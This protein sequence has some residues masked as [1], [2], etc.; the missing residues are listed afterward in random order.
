MQHCKLKQFPSRRDENS[1][2]RPGSLRN[3]AKAPGP[4]TCGFCTGKRLAF[5]SFRPW[6]GDNRS[7]QGMLLQSRGENTVRHPAPS[8]NPSRARNP[9]V[10]EVLRRWSQAK[11]DKGAESG[12]R[13]DVP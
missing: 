1:D 3:P 2:N 4:V 13:G 5:G 6:Q 11:E 12:S 10:S 7:A 9:D 8:Q